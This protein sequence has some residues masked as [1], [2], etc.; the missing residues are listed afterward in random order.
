MTGQVT[1][2]V[3]DSKY[4]DGVHAAGTVDQEMPRILDA[5]SGCAGPLAAERQMIRTDALGEF[6]AV[7]RAGTVGIGCDVAEGLLQEGL[8]TR[9]GA[10]TELCLAP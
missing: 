3:Q 6:A 10:H 1:T 8:V 2:V 5:A 4:L 9:C 7:L